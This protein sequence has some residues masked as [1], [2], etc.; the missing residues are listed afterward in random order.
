MNECLRRE[1]QSVSQSLGQ[2]ITPPSQATQ[3]RAAGKHGRSGRASDDE[4]VERGDSDPG[5]VERM[6][7]AEAVRVAGRGGV[8][9]VVQQDYALLP[10]L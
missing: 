10:A 4:I 6:S 8:V 1:G 2:S 9:D 3:S 7:L 5:D